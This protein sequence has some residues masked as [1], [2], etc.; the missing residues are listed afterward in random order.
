MQTGRGKGR[1]WQQGF[2]AEIKSAQGW[3]FFLQVLCS[4]EG[5]MGHFRT[6]LHLEFTFLQSVPSGRAVSNF[7]KA[8]ACKAQS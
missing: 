1:V 5:D 6:V 3:G 2:K 8:P 4:G 7:H